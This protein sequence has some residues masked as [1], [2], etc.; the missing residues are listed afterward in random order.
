MFEECKTDASRLSRI[1][2]EKRAIFFPF[3]LMRRMSRGRDLCVF[4]LH[5]A[6]GPVD[7]YTTT[8]LDTLDRATRRRAAQTV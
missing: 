4:R 3:L 2:A 5:S 6:V 8:T 7:V 1:P